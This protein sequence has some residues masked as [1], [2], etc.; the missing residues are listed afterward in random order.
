MSESAHVG[1]VEKWESG[2]M[3]NE[4]VRQGRKDQNVLDDGVKEKNLTEGFGDLGPVECRGG[5]GGGG[6]G[7]EG[8]HEEMKTKSP[9]YRCQP[10]YGG[11]QPCAC[12]FPRRPFS[13]RS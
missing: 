9:T 5:G 1:T 8:G 13:L 11:F 4:R 2:G 10:S 3:A 12:V 7:G 6:G